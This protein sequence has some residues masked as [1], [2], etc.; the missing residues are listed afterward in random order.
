MARLEPSISA[1]LGRGFHLG[2]HLPIDLRRAEIEYLLFDGTPYEPAYGDFHHRNEW[3]FGLGDARFVAGWTGEPPGS[4]L[5]VGGGVGVALPT[6]RTEEDP[7]AAAESQEEHQHLQFGNG[8]VDP[9]ASFRLIVR[10]ETLGMFSS[11]SGRF[12]LYANKK[13]YQGPVQ[14]RGSVGPMLRPPAPL[15]SLQLLLLAVVSGNWPERWQGELGQNSGLL[16]AGVHLGLI[17]NITPQLAVQGAM[18]ANA[19]QKSRGGQFTR[20]LTLTFG[21]SGFLDLRPKKSRGHP[22]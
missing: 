5:I 6:G 4:P 10:G 16:S 22:H 11:V 3:L 17:W 21:I 14:L 1:G 19:F 18:L 15:R 7:F 2:F 9:L 20:P 13:G 8:T 12:P